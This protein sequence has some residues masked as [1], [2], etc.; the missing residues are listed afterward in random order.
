MKSPI[1][2]L[3]QSRTAT[4]TPAREI[5]VVPVEEI[6]VKPKRAAELLAVSRTTLWRETQL[7]RLKQLPTGNYAVAELRRYASEEGK[8]V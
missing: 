5:C 2:H 7:G 4:F 8:A 6:A 3:Y 1:F